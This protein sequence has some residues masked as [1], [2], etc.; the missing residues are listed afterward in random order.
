MRDPFDNEAALSRFPGPVL[1][2][3]GRRDAMIPFDHARRLRDVAAHARLVA[4]DCDHNDCPPDWGRFWDDVRA[5]LAE[6]GVVGTGNAKL[7]TG[8]SRLEAGNWKLET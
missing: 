2:I 5:F 1:L 7:E 4:Y 6:A 8:N 3:H